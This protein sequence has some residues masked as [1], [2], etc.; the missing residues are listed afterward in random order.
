[1][2]VDLLVIGAGATGASIAME[3]AR[4]GLSVVLVE[5][6]DI[7]IGT[8]SRST[9]LLHG[10]V[11]YLELAFRRLDWRQLQL[12]REALAERGHWLEAVPFLARRLELLLP[13][14][15]L[16]QQAYYGLGLAVYDRL[17]GRAGIGSSRWLGRQA[18]Q[19]LLPEL[20]A[21]HVGVA[22]GDGQF[23]DARL[24]LL[25][26]R[27]AAHLGAEVFTRTEVVELLRQ[28]D[29]LSGAVL[30]DQ[31]TGQRRRLEARVVLNAT[32]IGADR[33]RQLAQPD[34]PPSL[35]VSRGVH[36]VLAADLCPGGRGC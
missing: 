11:R 2:S 3:A 35:Q 5:A 19:E 1:M 36:L 18:V 13:S 20:S 4:R 15:G 16:L 12:V 14:D 10:G 23:D 34:L 32:G 28:G 26:V 27:T 8:S 21:G 29:R 31:A 6:G 24:N 25:M 9:K 7:A 33:I 22:Y 30:H 17:A